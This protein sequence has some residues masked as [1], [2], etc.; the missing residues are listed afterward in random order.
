MQWDDDDKRV[1]EKKK[2]KKS[3]SNKF[4]NDVKVN[5]NAFGVTVKT[6][7]VNVKVLIVCTVA[8]VAL[9]VIAIGVGL[10]NNRPSRQE[11]FQSCWGLSNGQTGCTYRGISLVVAPCQNGHWDFDNAERCWSNGCYQYAD[12]AECG[13]TKSDLCNGRTDGIC[14]HLPDYS[15]LGTEVYD[16]NWRKNID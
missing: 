16:R 11:R 9:I 5:V 2:S 13:K 8:F 4:P 7:N 1:E 10:Y 14:G 12:V 6:L 3:P 15:Y